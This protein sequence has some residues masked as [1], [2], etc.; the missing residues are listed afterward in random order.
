MYYGTIKKTD[1]ANGPGIRISLFVSGCRNH[2]KGC[3][4]PETWDFCYGKPYTK[5]TEEEILKE[6]IL[7][8]YQGLTILGGEPFEEE[9]QKEV[10]NLIL[11]VKSELPDKDI[12]VY[13]GY[14][15]DKDLISEGRKHTVDTDEI[16]NNIDVLVDGRFEESRKNLSLN[17]RGSENQRIIDMRETRH[18]GKLCL[19]PLNN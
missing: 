10:K 6:L 2:C 12:W 16:L 17:F 1:C 4:Q 14:T 7:P 13:T 5:E 9:N 18:T 3:F 15:F 8:Y 19:H 11:R